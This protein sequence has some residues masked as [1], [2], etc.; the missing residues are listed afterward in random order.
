LYSQSYK[1]YITVLLLVVY[2]F[3][4]IDRAIFGI[5]MEPIKREF[6]L[7]DTQLGFL[8]GPA[9]ALFYALLGIPIAR[10][11]DRSHRINIMAAAIALWSII[12]TFSAAVQTFWQFALARLG[13]GI[14]EAGFSAVAQS[15]IGDYH[16][17]TERTRALSV[18]MLAL[19]LGAASSYLLGGWVNEL[20]GWRAV[21][22]VCGIPGL[23]LAVL[24]KITVR[25]PR[26][27]GPA[28]NPAQCLAQPPPLRSVFA[29]LW[30]RRA[31]RHLAIAMTLLTLITGGVLGWKAA[32]F[33][34]LH[35]MSTAQVG[36]WMA[37]IVGAGGGFGTW[38]S[39]HL[40]RALKIED[41]RKQTGMLAA[42][43]VLA[44]PI[45]LAALTWPDRSGALC[46]LLV[47]IVVLHLFFAPSFS[48][49]QG[50][51]SANVKATMVSIVI[52]FQI[53]FAGVIGLQLT[54]LLSDSLTATFGVEALRWAMV[55]MTPAALWAGV[56]FW[57]ASRSIRNDLTDNEN[58]ERVG[59]ASI[60]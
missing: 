45:L 23:I 32:F 3:N 21:F 29:L 28:L 56:H 34:R 37:L 49:V 11:A 13:V 33:I 53:L 39:G 31:L 20:Y 40:T 12:V 16:H 25:E 27:N 18:F 36:S 4:Q 52:F 6:M 43:A 10:W 54:G 26:R 22:I 51:C 1:R 35:G 17:A 41:E 8:A 7:T 15:V 60:A 30:Q 19:P 55:L 50:L 47:A 57:L 9:L 5:L 14:G 24:M 42:S 38:L 2:I 46:L 44:W 58:D 48:L 59:N